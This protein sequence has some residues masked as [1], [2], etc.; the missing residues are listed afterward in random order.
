MPSRVS[1]KR[2]AQ[3]IFELAREHNQLDEWAVDLQLVDQALQDPEFRTFLTHADVPAEQKIR[4]VNAVLRDVNPLVRN[5][6]DVLVVKGLTSIAAELQAAYTDLLDGHHGRQRVEVTSAV[7]LAD[8]ELDR[9]TRFISELTRREVVVTTQVD[10]SI[11]GGIVI[12]IG[13]QLLD[14]S[15]RSRLESLRNQMHSAVIAPGFS[16]GREGDTDGV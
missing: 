15:T 11:M 14:G 1:G 9:V 2:Y 4:A 10:E 8:S 12:Q 7:P 5:L 16:A 3:A 13:D 6:V